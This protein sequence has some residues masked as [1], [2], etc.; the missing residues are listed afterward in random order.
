MSMYYDRLRALTENT[1]SRDYEAS[2][3]TANTTE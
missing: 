2:T 1:Q 3:F